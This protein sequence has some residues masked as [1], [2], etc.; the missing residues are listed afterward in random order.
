MRGISGK[1]LPSVGKNM[2]GKRTGYSLG[3]G[4]KDRGTK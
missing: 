2:D 3:N 4:L 1:I